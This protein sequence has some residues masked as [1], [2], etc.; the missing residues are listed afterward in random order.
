MRKELKLL[1]DEIANPENKDKNYDMLC[2]LSLFFN[3]E[4][5]MQELDEIRKY[6]R[7]TL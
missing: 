6:A 7:T 1:W 5:S 4:I 2:L 3:G